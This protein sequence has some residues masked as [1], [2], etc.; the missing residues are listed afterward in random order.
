MSSHVLA[1][2]KI[3]NIFWRIWSMLVES[4]MDI[5]ETLQSIA[6]EMRTP[7][8][9]RMM[10]QAKEDIENRF[11]VWKALEETNI[12]P[13]HI[14]ALLHIGEESGRLPKNLKMVALQQ[15]KQR[16]LVSK[17]SLFSRLSAYCF[18]TFSFIGIGISWFIL[19]RLSV[20]FAQLKLIFP[21]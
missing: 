21:L 12:L 8:M 15:Q 7:Q 9:R 5:P 11:P 6:T 17:S 3:R 1:L 16:L 2:R 20:V 18:V 10:K 4:G 19:P 14:I 13:A